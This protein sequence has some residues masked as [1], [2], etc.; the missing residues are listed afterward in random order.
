MRLSLVLAALALAPLD[1][2]AEDPAWRFRPGTVFIWECRA[3]STFTSVRTFKDGVTRTVASPSVCTLTLSATVESVGDDGGARLAFEV[4]RVEMDALWH[5]TGARAK[6]DSRKDRDVVP[7]FTRYAAIAGHR[8]TA[9]VGG[10]GEIREM[11]GSEWP[12]ESDLPR[13]K[14]A[15][16]GEE[17]AAATMRDP[18]P[19]R[20]WLDLIF[21]TAPRAGAAWSVSLNL[22]GTETLDASP[23]G[24]DRVDGAE[25][26]VVKLESPKEGKE[27]PPV[28]KRRHGRAWFSASAGCLVKVELAGVEEAARYKPGSEQQIKWSAS[29]KSRTEGPAK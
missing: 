16:Q 10:D 1:I 15:S 9:L 14:N 20:T 23:G 17:N 21:A 12:A 13:K 8:F 27:A 5:D 29:L 3:E 24:R 6:W 11:K 28:S 18:D 19:A 22:P 7:G 26:A 2:A 4:T 25:C